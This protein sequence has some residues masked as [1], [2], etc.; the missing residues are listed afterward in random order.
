V[1]TFDIPG[2]RDWH[3]VSAAV[4]RVRLAGEPPI[5]LKL[6]EQAGEGCQFY[7]FSHGELSWSHRAGAVQLPDRAQLCGT[8][9]VTLDGRS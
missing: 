5:I 3:G 8:E 6:R 9:A 2:R 4:R 7:P 1:L